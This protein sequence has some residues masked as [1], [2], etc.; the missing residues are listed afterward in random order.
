MIQ[1]ILA[2]IEKGGTLTVPGLAAE[3]QTTPALVEMMLEDLARRGILKNNQ[4]GDQCSSD[5]CGSCYF[6][7]SCSTHIQRLW[8]A[9]EKGED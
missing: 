7:K 6:A 1:K 2:L 3:L 8:T 9:P 5:V 4:F